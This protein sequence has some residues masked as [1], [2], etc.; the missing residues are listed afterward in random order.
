M[1]ER[2]MKGE[3]KGAPLMFKTGESMVL[4][5]VKSFMPRLEIANLELENKD[6]EDISIENVDE[7]AAHIEMVITVYLPQIGYNS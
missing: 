5:K 7:N 4:S 1:V 3:D 6:P 2:L